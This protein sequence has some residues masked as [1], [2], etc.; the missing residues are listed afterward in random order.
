MYCSSL[1]LQSAYFETDVNIPT[2]SQWSLCSSCVH[3]AQRAIHESETL[4]LCFPG[5]K[6]VNVGKDKASAG[7]EDYIYD[8]PLDDD[9]DF[10]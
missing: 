7:L 8:D 3:L 6:Y 10:M 4:A 5:K 1:M 9:Y 2:C